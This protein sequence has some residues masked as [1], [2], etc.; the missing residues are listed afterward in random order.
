MK[1]LFL[2]AFLF[3]SLI[4]IAEETNKT[5]NVI[6]VTFDGYRWQDLFTGADEKLVGN[7]KYVGDPE[8]LKLQYWA[9]SADERRKKLMPFFWN[10]I[11]KQGTLI[12]NRKLKC[13][14]DVT[15]GYKFS[16]PGYSEIFCGYGDH[17]INSN[18]YPDNPNKNIF[19][20]LSTQKGFEN[21]EAAFATWDA[22]PRIINTN[23]NKVPVFV[24]FKQE[25]NIVSCAT[26][27]YSKWLSTC[28]PTNPFAKTDTMTYHFAKEY[29]QGNHPRFAFIGFDETDDFAHEGKYDA[30][31]NTANMEDRFM[32]DLWNFIQS[33]PVYKDKTTLIITCDHGRGH[34]RPGMWRHHGK[35]VLDAHQ[36]WLA[37]LGPDTPAKGEVSNTKKY[38]QKQIAQTVAHLLGKNY[39]DEH[40]IGE[41]IDILIHTKSK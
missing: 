37:A 32:E 31:L 23:R 1:N 33:D 34:K 41:A 19:D 17:R 28:P 26:V 18:D 4:I 2:I 40:P 6:L 10:T 15:N 9:S 29:I 36:I 30:Y 12:G 35:L 7:K 14:M 38:Y 25:K 3:S 11:A 24:N 21:K 8:K 20:F 16:Y 27:S 39:T 22:F 13:K 5:E